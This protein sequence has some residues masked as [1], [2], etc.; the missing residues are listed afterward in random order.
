MDRPVIRIARDQLPAG[1]M[2]TTTSSSPFLPAA[3]THQ[4]DAVS[5]DDEQES[6]RH[7]LPQ[8]V[9]PAADMSESTTANFSAVPPAAAAVSTDSASDS[10]ASSVAAAPAFVFSSAPSPAFVS[11][12][13]FSAVQQF[14]DAHIR[15]LISRCDKAEAGLV[16]ARGDAV[17]QSA[18]IHH[19]EQQVA[20]LAG[21]SRQPDSSS[22]SIPE[23]SAASLVPPVPPQPAPL[24]QQQQQRQPRQRQ[25]QPRH[26]P[27][28]AS[29]MRA[30]VHSMPAPMHASMQQPSCPHKQ[31]PQQQQ[32]QQ[33]PQPHAAHTQ[34]PRPQQPRHLPRPSRQHRTFAD[35]TAAEPA[36]SPSPRPL[37]SPAPSLA[38]LP[39]RRLFSLRGLHGAHGT[40]YASFNAAPRRTL[41]AVNEWLGSH[42]C[43]VPSTSFPSL[44]DAYPSGPPSAST[45]TI[46]VCTMADAALLVHHRHR[47]KG[48]M[49]A[50]R[51]VILADVLSPEEEMEHRRLLPAFRRARAAGQPAQFHRARLMVAGMRVP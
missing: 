34:Q 26:S 1:C 45:V 30:P 23:R 31:H 12:A 7:C 5:S 3:V 15:H 32:Q 9:S 6:L 39:F 29:P 41:N 33:Q 21:L 19:L 16:A 48:H 44:V 14:H 8:L 36:P 50:G 51:H 35:V 28:A 49:E 4:R 2:I 43:G 47:L 40:D 38:S 20:Q 13:E 37:S 10:G 17:I 18:R 42:L 22:S 11:H 46:E 25:S 24:Q 27:P